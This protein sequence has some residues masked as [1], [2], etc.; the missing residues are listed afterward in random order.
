MPINQVY[1]RIMKAV[2]TRFV[3]FQKV[4]SYFDLISELKWSF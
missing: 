3:V 2:K 4:S 1:A